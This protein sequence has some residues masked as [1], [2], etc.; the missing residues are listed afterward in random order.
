MG[1]AYRL[2]VYAKLQIGL[3]VTYSTSF[4]QIEILFPF[5]SIFISTEKHAHGVY[6]FGIEHNP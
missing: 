5:F 6:I 3:C 1:S 4:S 2:S